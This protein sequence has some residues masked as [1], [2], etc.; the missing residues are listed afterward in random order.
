MVEVEINLR[1]GM[2]FESVGQDGVPVAL[3]SDPVHGGR[4]LGHRPME[5]ILVALGS[6]TAM[7]VISIL[8]KM[9]QHVTG[10]R[11]EVS[12]EQ[13]PSHPHVFTQISLRHIISGT[14]VREE[15]VQRA[16]ELSEQTYCPAY[17]MLSK[18]VPI[19]TS[20]EVLEAPA[21]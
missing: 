17:A 3:D 15:A 2:H 8:R 7:D 20:Y 10:Y 19:A 1:E 21:D 14:H 6:C 9:R 4:G 16:I 18:A 12:G 11:V 13:A 5:L